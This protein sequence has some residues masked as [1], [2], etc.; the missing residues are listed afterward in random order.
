MQPADSGLAYRTF[1]SQLRQPRSRGGIERPRRAMPRARSWQPNQAAAKVREALVCRLSERAVRRARVRV[2]HRLGQR[3]A[4]VELARRLSGEQV[5]LVNGLRVPACPRCGLPASTAPSSAP[6]SR[7]SPE[8][9]SSRA[10]P[11]LLGSG[12]IFGYMCVERSST[13]REHGQVGVA[14]RAPERNLEH[15]HSSAAVRI[16]VREGRR[17][18]AAR[19]G[20]GGARRRRVVAAGAS[21]CW[22]GDCAH[23]RDFLL[24]HNSIVNNLP[25]LAEEG[26]SRS[27]RRDELAERCPDLR[28]A[29]AG[30]ALAADL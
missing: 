4:R 15:H 30:S 20:R 5:P 17:G 6:R 3:H 2:G 1:A 7:N 13:A 9:W 26:K 19:R 10:T 18:S 12:R 8:K 29:L 25:P 16:D 28:A 14:H 27:R 21:G 11:G 22:W 23:Q 24:F